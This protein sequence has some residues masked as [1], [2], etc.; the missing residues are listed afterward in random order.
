[1]SAPPLRDILHLAKLALAFGRKN[2]ATLH[3][4]GWTPESDTDHTV[5]LALIAPALAHALR[6]DLQPDLVAA[7][8]VVHDLAEVK[9]GDTNTFGISAEDLAAKVVREAAA[10]EELREE[11]AAF[12]WIVNLLERYELQQEPEARWCRYVDKIMPKLTH[13]FNGGVALLHMPLKDAPHI[14]LRKEGDALRQTL[15]DAYPEFPELDV[16]YGEALD[17]AV[18]AAS[19]PRGA[20]HR[21]RRLQESADL[22]K[23]FGHRTA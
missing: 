5:M 2:R 23:A 14:A 6:P 1:M 7:F 9:V 8:V 15:R 17:V 21:L 10:L 3:P 22:L 11:L 12:P 16:L 18:A 4:D 13:S 20:L 19:V